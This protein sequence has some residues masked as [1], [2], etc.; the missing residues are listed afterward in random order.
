MSHADCLIRNGTGR[1][2]VE[3]RKEGGRQEERK[4]KGGERDGT[5]ERGKETGRQG[6]LQ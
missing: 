1:E 6:E 5:R 4:I 3:S 2:E